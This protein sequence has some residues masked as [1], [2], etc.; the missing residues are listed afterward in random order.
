MFPRI[1]VT[2]G[3]PHEPDS[4]AV[5]TVDMILDTDDVQDGTKRIAAMEL[6]AKMSRALTAHY[7]RVRDEERNSLRSRGEGAL[8]AQFDVEQYLDGAVIDLVSAA[9]GTPW[10]KQWEAPAAREQARALLRQHF[11]DAKHVER[12]WYSDPSLAAQQHRNKTYGGASPS[13]AY[14]ATH[15]GGV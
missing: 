5:A 1:L 15:T 11:T 13:P 10:E 4:W 6:K 7:V 12:L 9:V 2:N 14:H 8:F 3:G